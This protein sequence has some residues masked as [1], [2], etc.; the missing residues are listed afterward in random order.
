MDICWLRLSRCF[1]IAWNW[2][3]IVLTW[4]LSFMVY[5]TEVAR[6]NQFWID[7][8]LLVYT[9]YE[10]LYAAVVV[11]TTLNRWENRSIT[12][13]DHWSRGPKIYLISDRK[14]DIDAI[15]DRPTPSPIVL[16]D[17][18]FQFVWRSSNNNHTVESLKRS[19]KSSR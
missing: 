12:D 5:N 16:L 14:N 6:S 9:S 18:H 1:N 8:V 2:L 3:V 10:L 13:Y 4:Y 11:G 19:C 7:L 17:D 15:L